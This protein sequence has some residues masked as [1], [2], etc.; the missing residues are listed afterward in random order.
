MHV[1]GCIESDSGG[2]GRGST[3]LHLAAR[4]DNVDAL[5]LLL[6]FHAPVN[7]RGENGW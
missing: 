4:R 7:A 2:R 1:M 5:T 3:A 6:H